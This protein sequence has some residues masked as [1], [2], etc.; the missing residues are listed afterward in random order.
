MKLSPIY[1]LAIFLLSLPLYGQVASTIIQLK[2]PVRSPQTV[3]LAIMKV[4]GNAHISQFTIDKED[5]IVTGWIEYE[6]STGIIHRF[7]L[8]TRRQVTQITI[9]VVRTKTGITLNGSQEFKDCYESF[10]DCDVTTSNPADFI[11]TTSR[12]ADILSEVKR[13][14]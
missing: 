7:L 6:E 2:Q 14:L 1:S 11:P 3:Y 10:S 9:R 13:A 12:I 8:G 4:L 5:H